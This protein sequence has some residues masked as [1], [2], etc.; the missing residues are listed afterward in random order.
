MLLLLCFMLFPTVCSMSRPGLNLNAG[1]IMKIELL[2]PAHLEFA[3]SSEQVRIEFQNAD[4]EPAGSYM[5]IISTYTDRAH[6]LALVNFFNSLTLTSS[7]VLIDAARPSENF[8]ITYRDGT[9]DFIWFHFTSL[10][11]NDSFFRITDDDRGLEKTR[12][13]DNLLYGWPDE[14]KRLR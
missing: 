1:N 6:I 10:F 11:H 7:E 8:R 12:E 13:L 2:I 4:G 5:A 3:A 14:T 9:T